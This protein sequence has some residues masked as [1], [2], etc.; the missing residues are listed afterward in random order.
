MAAR[1]TSRYAEM[2]RIAVSS[3]PVEVGRFGLALVTGGGA[4]AR[5]N[6][7]GTE[8]KVRP[9]SPDV[10]VVRSLMLGEFDEA[11][12]RVVLRSNLVVD[13]GGYIG[14]TGMLFAKAFPKARI[15]VL[16]PSTENFALARE[17]TRDF[18]NVTVLKAALAA[19]DGVVV[20]KDRGTGPWGFTIVNEAADKTAMAA[21]GEVEAV[22]IPTLLKRFGAEGIDLLKLDIEGGEHDLLAARP[23]WVERC[24]VIVAELHDRIHPGCTAVFEAAMAGRRALPLVGEKIISLSPDLGAGT[25]VWA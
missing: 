22:S 16:E 12:S 18:P 5:L 24:G 11:I 4:P 9:N 21:L 13:A 8:L 6:F 2:L 15:V 25:A 23:Q 17:N 7:R 20:L 10:L 14:A 19:E 3:N 1:P